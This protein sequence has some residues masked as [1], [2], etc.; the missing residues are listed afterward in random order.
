MFLKTCAACLA[1]ALPVSSLGT[2]SVS[3]SPLGLGR[4][5]VRRTTSKEVA[6]SGPELRPAE[7]SGPKLGVGNSD[8]L[9][10]RSINRL[11]LP[12]F[13]VPSQID[14]KEKFKAGG[15]VEAASLPSI[16]C[17]GGEAAS[18]IQSSPLRSEPPKAAC[19]HLNQSVASQ[20]DAMLATESMA[21]VGKASRPLVWT[22]MDKSYATFAADQAAQLA[23]VGLPHIIFVSIDPD[24]S[25]AEDLCAKGFATINFNPLYSTG[26]D[27]NIK[28]WSVKFRVAKAKFMM[29]GMLIERRLENLFTESDVFWQ[30]DPRAQLTYTPDGSPAPNLIMATHHNDPTSLNIGVWYIPATAGPEVARV[31]STAWDIMYSYAA[32]PS[33]PVF[34]QAVV[35]DLLE[36]I[37]RPDFQGRSWCEHVAGAAANRVYCRDVEKA[38]PMTGVNLRR[39]SNRL[40]SSAKFGER[41][42][43]TLAVHILTGQPL[44][45]GTSKIL[46]AKNAG[47]FRGVPTYYEMEKS[48]LRYLAWDG[49]LNHPSKEQGYCKYPN[50]NSPPNACGIGKALPVLFSLGARFGLTVVPP[51]V[52]D[53]NERIWPAESLFDMVRFAEDAPF[54]NLQVRESKFLHNELLNITHMYPVVRLRVGTE[55]WVAMQTIDAEGATPHEHVWST[56]L[57]SNP[58]NLGVA[59]VLATLLTSGR[60][61]HA[62]TVLVNFPTVG[63]HTRGPCVDKALCGLELDDALT[64]LLSGENCRSAFKSLAR[65]SRWCSKNDESSLDLEA[66]FLC[67]E[68]GMRKKH[69]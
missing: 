26:S 49:L 38:L 42:E 31:F 23:S 61:A 40:I 27:S 39:L 47:V 7:S 4:S 55:G 10:Q 41:D 28:E 6:S 11:K 36:Y 48:K 58:R 57:D 20:L 24:P 62:K 8:L 66:R 15:L 63:L 5:V 65:T 29:P 30:A 2:A 64:Y 3:I 68:K 51:T 18:M 56:K 14:S 45:S 69:R 54:P 13:P 22:V 60:T 37:D 12:P 21:G 33:K 43:D 67:Q 25:V 32:D 17:N 19:R 46:T 53:L 59:S 50:F 1:L 34:D 9:G 35:Q 16:E 44:S 52:L